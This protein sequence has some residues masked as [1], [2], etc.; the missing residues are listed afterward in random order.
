MT[1]EPT[2]APASFEIKPRILLG[3]GPSIVLRACWRR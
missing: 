3:P 1:V 2:L